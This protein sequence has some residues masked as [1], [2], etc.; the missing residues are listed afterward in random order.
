V[1]EQQLQQLFALWS[2]AG[3]GGQLG[4]SELCQGLGKLQRPLRTKQACVRRC[5][6]RGG[7]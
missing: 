4:F 2:R 1:P 3:S 5:R 7:C 6:G